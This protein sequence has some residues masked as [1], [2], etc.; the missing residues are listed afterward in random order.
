MPALTASPGPWTA[1]TL[2]G[3]GLL[4]AACVLVV[5]PAR[6]A[7]PV[8]GPVTIS[9]RL[10]AQSRAGTWTMM[11]LTFDN[12]SKRRLVLSLYTGFRNT[13]LVRAGR[14][15]LQ[16]EWADGRW[17]DARLAPGDEE[18]FAIERADALPPGRSTMVYRLRSASGPGTLRVRVLAVPGA[19][20]VRADF[21]HPV[22]T[23]AGLVTVVRPVAAPGPT[24][25]HGRRVAGTASPAT[26]VAVTPAVSGLV[27]PAASVSAAHLTT[28]AQVGPTLPV[29]ASPASA[30]LAARER[31]SVGGGVLTL[32]AL[33]AGLLLAVAGVVVL[34]RRARAQR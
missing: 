16:R 24:A 1:R 17:T 12:H 10:P 19:H 15:R 21:R 20:H 5:G 11:R 34:M 9:M 26:G 14:V 8:N 32:A 2:G 30:P 33:V 4:G 28:P 31:R 23:C 6:A 13:G 29:G 22:A 3:L 18:Y 25:S 27:T 7:A